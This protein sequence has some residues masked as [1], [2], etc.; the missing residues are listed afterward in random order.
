VRKLLRNQRKKAKR[1]NRDWNWAVNGESRRRITNTLALAQSVPPLNDRGDGWDPDPMLLGAPNGVIDLTTGT[2]RP[3]APEDRVTLR[4]R[5]CW[6]I[7]GRVAS[8]LDRT[9][10]FPKP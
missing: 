4:V 5:V 9:F 7:Q 6:R 1:M 8:Q 3:A 2:L 10:L